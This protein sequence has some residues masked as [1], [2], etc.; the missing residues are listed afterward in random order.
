[1]IYLAAPDII[2]VGLG[3]LEQDRWMAEDRD[4]MS[5]S[6]LMGVGAAFDFIAGNLKQ[7]PPWAQR[8][9]IERLYRLLQEPAR[10]WKR[11]NRYPLFG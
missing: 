9:G 10:L 8:V 6:I 4:R 5:A 7:S 3:S 11:Y 1:M 2:W